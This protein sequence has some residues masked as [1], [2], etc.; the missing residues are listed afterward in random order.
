MVFTE[1]KDSHTAYQE[2]A[3]VYDS[4]EILAVHRNS[5]FTM[6]TRLQMPMVD[7]NI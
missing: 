4:M 5:P 3:V 1:Y 2:M 6:T 7:A